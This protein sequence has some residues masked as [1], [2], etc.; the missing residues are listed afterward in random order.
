LRR[1]PVQVSEGAAAGA[2]P[3]SPGLLLTGLKH[4]RSNVRG[5]AL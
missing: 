3:A 5:T 4:Y 1:A 2:R